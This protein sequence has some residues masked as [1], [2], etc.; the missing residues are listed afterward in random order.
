VVVELDG[1]G[2]MN[3]AVSVR[4]G[5]GTARASLTGRRTI[6]A[7]SAPNADKM[8]SRWADETARLDH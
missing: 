1:D 6:R 5:S 4:R 3:L 2:D 8:R 7:G